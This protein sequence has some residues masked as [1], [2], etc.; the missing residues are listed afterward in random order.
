M[1]ETSSKP[2]WPSLRSNTLRW[3]L[4]IEPWISSWF[5]ARHASSYGVPFTR[6]SG[7]R[8]TTCRQKKL[9][10]STAARPSRVNMPLTT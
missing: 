1:P 4:A 8:A 6:V 10:R 9:S 2:P 7:D 3:R 5:V